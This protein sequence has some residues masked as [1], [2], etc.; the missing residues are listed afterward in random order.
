MDLP[1]GGRS[2]LAVGSGR[3]QRGAMEIGPL[4]TPLVVSAQTGDTL[5]AVARRLWAHG[6][7]SLPVFEGARLVG[8]IGERDLVTAIA[9]GATPES[10]AAAHMSRGP[11]TAHPA[12]D[13]AEVARRMLDL[14]VRHLPV[15]DGGGRVVGMV[16]ARDLLQLV[17]WPEPGPPVL[18]AGA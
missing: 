6:I 17:A 4:V 18:A 11:A 13:S 16:A 2:P 14:G 1:A 7:G 10:A 5:A 15:V 12:D 9:L 8:M 3:C